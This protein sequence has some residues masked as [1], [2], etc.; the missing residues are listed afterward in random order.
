MAQLTFALFAYDFPH[1]RTQEFMQ[2]LHILGHRCEVFAAPWRELKVAPQSERIFL[3]RQSLLHPATIA[4]AYGWPYHVIAHDDLTRDDRDNSQVTLN[5]MGVNYQGSF[6]FG[7]IAGARIL[8]KELIALFGEGI[9]NFHTGLLPELRGLDTPL[10]AVMDDQPPFITAHWIADKIDV[11]RFICKQ[12]VPLYPD[13]TLVD[14]NERLF[15]M[16][17]RLLDVAIAQIQRRPAR[18]FPAIDITGHRV[19][20]KM[21]AGK[22]MQ[23]RSMFPAWRDRWISKG[24][25]KDEVRI[26]LA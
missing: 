14:F 15:E 1:L 13:D 10:W 11:G 24:Y 22:E 17:L 8:S 21:A 26:W 16:Q 7:L 20:E 19:H 6:G 3:R 4:R 5:P 12:Q 23:A 2:R 9:I 25:V 18:D